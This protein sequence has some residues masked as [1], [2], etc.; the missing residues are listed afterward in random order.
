MSLPKKL[1]I[2]FIFFLILFLILI[3]YFRLKFFQEK[4]KVKIQIGSQNIIAYVAF[5]EEEKRK[6]LSGKSGLG[7]NE[8]ML[9]V[10]EKPGKYGFWMKDMLFPIDIVWIKNKKVVGWEEN[11]LPPSPQT[12]ES[13]LKIYYPPQD[14]DLVLELPAKKSSSLNLKEGMDIFIKPIFLD[15]KL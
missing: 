7:E 12:K 9:F 6:G 1:K 3:F 15:L 8:G 4:D 10:F 13:E 14:V 11:I 2:F 5:S